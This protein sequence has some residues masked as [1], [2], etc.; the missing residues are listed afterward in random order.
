LT[1]GREDGEG[2]GRPRAD[3]SDRRTIMGTDNVDP[4]A[5]NHLLAHL[6]G[7]EYARL[8]EHGEL[9]TMEVKDLAYAANGPIPHVYFPLT[10]VYSLITELDDGSSME[11][12]TI[13]NEG[14]VGLPVFLGAET[15]PLTTFSQIAGA[16]LCLDAGTFRALAVPG[17]ALHEGL[18][19]FTQAL[20]ILTAQSVACN[21]LHEVRARCARWLLMTH[22]RVGTD[23]FLLTHEFMAQMLGVRR[24]SVT[25]VMGDLQAR[26]LITYHRGE[27]TIL[28]RPGLEGA[29]CECYR[30]I[31]AEF[32]RLV[33]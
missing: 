2:A 15:S 11:V 26:G 19:R 25:D 22:D 28:D 29:A 9:V 32:D 24:A 31:K 30:I 21:R 17:T 18:H 6:P 14:F 13:G 16:S 12:A 3:G 1:G 27:V 33:G 8:R 5:L 4:R 7:D 23:A 10:S 20:F